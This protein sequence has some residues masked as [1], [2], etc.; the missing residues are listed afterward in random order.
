MNVR[1]ELRK[2]RGK[3]KKE[4]R[5]MKKGREKKKRKPKL[6]RLLELKRRGNKS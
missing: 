2:L 1:E 6:R 3:L 5:G 4:I